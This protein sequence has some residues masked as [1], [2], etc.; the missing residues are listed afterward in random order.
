LCSKQLIVEQ[1]TMTENTGS[2]K[3]TRREI[4]RAFL[5]MPAS[6]ILAACAAQEISNATPTSLPPTAAPPLPT[7]TNAAAADTPIPAE[8]ALTDTSP[9]AATDTAAPTPTEGVQALPPTPACG[10]D[11]DEPTL[12]QT[13][14]PYYT[15]NTPERTS[16]LEPGMAGTKMVVTGYVLSTGCQ[17]VAQALV[18]FWHCDDAGVY[19]NEGY[20]LR[21]HQFADDQGRYY[22]ETIGP[23]VYPGRTRHIHVRVQAPNQPVLTT[24]MYFPDEPGNTSDGIFQPELLMDVQ[25]VSD[26][27]SAAFNFVLAIA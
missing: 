23:G 13:E 6:V 14:G 2:P 18:D 15:P 11:D 4:L 7:P 3:L 17:P 25:D 8:P 20:R 19:D 16:L 24:Q 27:K 12:A 22:L 21:G 1:G 9:A 5:A 10:D 26:G